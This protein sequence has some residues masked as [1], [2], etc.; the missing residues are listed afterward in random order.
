[1]KPNSEKIAYIFPGQGSQ[2]VGM[3]LDLANRFD[4]CKELFKQA[5][6]IVGYELSKVIWEGPVEELNDTINTQPALYLHSIAALRILEKEFPEI[7]PFLIAGHSLGEISAL[8]C[9]DAISF[10]NGLELVR[11]RGELMKNAGKTNPGGMAAVIGMEVEAL[12]AICDQVSSENNSVQIANDNCPGQ[13]VI[14]GNIPALDKAIEMAKNNGARKIR[15]LAVSIAAHSRLMITAQRGFKIAIEGI[16]EFKD[17]SVPIISNVKAIPITSAGD[18]KE[19]ILAQ[20]TSR[21]RWTESIKY[22]QSLGVKTFIEIGCGDVLNGL[23][24]RIY[25]DCKVYS[26]G[27]LNDIDDLR[28]EMDVS[29]RM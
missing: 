12:N 28:R 8:V 19:D 29:S 23:V 4:Y 7:K 16:N 24:K 2:K 17:I 6:G 27:E 13:I 22:I 9:A 15:P 20:L 14:S 5:D 18:L 26:F 10:E 21:V 25:E 3:G 11:K 1:M